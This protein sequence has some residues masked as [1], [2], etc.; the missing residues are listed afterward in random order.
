M[1]GLAVSKLFFAPGSKGQKKRK[2]QRFGGV[3]TE[4]NVIDGVDW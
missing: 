3:V 1:V 4:H 2:E